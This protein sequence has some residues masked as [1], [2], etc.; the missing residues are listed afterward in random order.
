MK[1]GRLQDIH[2]LVAKAESST[3]TRWAREDVSEIPAPWIAYLS[4]TN[5]CNA[6]CRVCARAK[7]MRSE[8]GL[9]KRDVF[10]R[11]LSQLPDSVQKVYLMKQGEP[12]LN[13]EL[14]YFARRLKEERPDISVAF[15]TNGIPATRD[16][17]LPVLPYV[18]SLGFSVGAIDKDT[19][20]AVHGTAG[21]ERVLE[22]LAWVSDYLLEQPKE[23]RPHFFIDYVVQEANKHVSEDDVV[24]FFSEKF[25]ALSSVD[26]HV[27][28]N[29]QGEI[30][31]ADFGLDKLAKA[32]EFPCCTLPWGMVTFLHD[33]N[34][35]YCSVEPRENAF[36]GN[37]MKQDFD[38]IWNG[39]PYSEFRADMAA[40]A[41]DSLLEKGYYCKRCSWLWY[42][43]TQ[44][45]RSLVGGSAFPQRADS[46]FAEL[47]Q[48]DYS[49][50]FRL[51]VESYGGGDIHKAAIYLRLVRDLSCNGELQSAASAVLEMTDAV[52]QKYKAPR[53]F[54]IREQVDLGRNV[55]H[56]M[57][58]QGN[59]DER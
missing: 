58:E 45:P 50:A 12:L 4:V 11:I 36:L 2:A 20:K 33:G 59:S 43:P 25:P 15:H 29:F 40:H 19:H 9:M 38:E 37:I 32:D 31:E 13:R 10:E 7:T 24:S 8:R 1:G 21:Y 49:E 26:I 44:S 14:P 42:M 18:D 28:F 5:V 41:M 27:A 17:L 16:R 39:Q 54:M 34:V 51:G 3:I 57:S 56:G 55:Y 30:S 6:K 23:Q 48:M 47:M 46:S 35:G 22:N 52:L 53:D